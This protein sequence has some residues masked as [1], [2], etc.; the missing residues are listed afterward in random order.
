MNDFNYLKESDVYLDSA[1][2]SLR[3]EPVIE[4]LNAY[5]REFN[6][7][8]ERVKYPWGETT[9]RKVNATRDKVL[10]YLGLKKK[11]YFVSFTLNTTYG[12][13]LLLSQFDAQKAGVKK[14]ITSDIE[15]NSPFL[16]TIA[17]S[18]RT[19]LPRE[20]IERNDDGS[21][22][23]DADF[24]RALVVVNAA[25][26]IDGRR[27]ENIKD[28]EKTVHQNGGFLIIDAAQ[29]MAHSKDILE[30]VPA[31]A[32]CFSAH[33]MYAPSLGG[34]VVRRDLLGYLDTSFV[35]GGMVS[36]VDRDTYDLLSVEPEHAY[37]KF[38]SGLQAWGEIVALGA[39][40]DWLEG[41]KKSDHKNLEDN[42]TELYNFLKTREKVHVIN[43]APNPTI[44]IYVDKAETGFDSHFLGS[45]LADQGIMTR[46]G[47]F[48]VHYYLDHVKHYPPLLRFSLGY[49]NRP[50]DI[51]RV[52][53][54]LANL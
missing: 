33:K 44:S 13:N 23:L 29:A 11:D 54:A 8:G 45:A 49:H 10:K 27:L 38:E 18:R 4:A 20:V 37:T 21:L 15:H 7:C 35:G 25:S 17:F 9:D 34:M 30:K 39:A 26:N 40:I 31:D 46:T 43:Q 28:L 32:I 5:Y 24:S 19:A 14:I 50:S 42:Y 47:Y 41:L 6:S 52:K 12:L 1:C 51:E 3:P 2:Q 36:D 53:S 16:S 48:C 22:P